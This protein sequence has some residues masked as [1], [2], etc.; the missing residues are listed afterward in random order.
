MQKEVQE[1]PSRG[2]LSYPRGGRCELFAV[3]LARPSERAPQ[4]ITDLGD[5]DWLRFQQLP[6]YGGLGAR[7]SS[8]FQYVGALSKEYNPGLEKTF[9]MWMARG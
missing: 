4:S 3:Q 1:Q 8:P 7:G 6:T 9:L 2:R 5:G